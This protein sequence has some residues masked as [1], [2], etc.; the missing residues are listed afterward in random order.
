MKIIKLTTFT[1]LGLYLALAM[2]IGSGLAWAAE[3]CDRACLEGIM[4][5]FLEAMVA[6]DPGAVA[7]AEGVKYTENGQEIE[8]GDALWQTATD[9]STYRLY[10]T[11]AVAGQAGFLGLIKENG[12][13]AFV[14]ARLKI[15]NREITEIE[16]MVVRDNARIYQP[17]NMVEPVPILVQTLAP[18]ERSSRADMIA[19]ADS[20]F[21]G[22]DEYNSGSRVPFDDDCQRLENGRVSANSSDPEATGM[23][24]MGCAEQFNT[25]FSTFVTDISDRRFPVIDEERGLIY[26]SVFFEHTGTIKTVELNNGETMQ[27]PTD[28]RRPFSWMIHEIFKIKNGK[29]RQIEALLLAVPFGMQS[30][31]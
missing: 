3:D 11:D 16:T 14:S 6:R 7:L 15:L 29:I 9:N 27:V 17:E 12:T 24:A 5:Q 1:G 21:S 26:T 10:I 8:I 4:D 25:G 22:L 13:A 28:Y 18:E 23:Q 2:P 30:G 31:W 19:I 20:Y